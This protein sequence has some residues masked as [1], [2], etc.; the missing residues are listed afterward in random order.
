M[1]QALFPTLDDLRAEHVLVQAW[2]K[3]ATY[4][5]QHSWYADTLELDYQSLRLP[6]FI[7]ELQERLQSPK[8]WV[9]TPLEMVP[10]PKSQA[11]LYDGKVWKPKESVH[12]KIRPLAHVALPDQVLATAM[13]L[14]LADQVEGR[15]GDPL[16]SIESAENRK[17]VLAYG[18]RLFC[19]ST[20]GL[21]HRWGSSKLFRLYYRDYQ[22]FLRRPEIVASQLKDKAAGRE[23]AIV[24]SDLSK[25][26]DRVRPSLLREQVRPLTIGNDPQFFALFQKVFAWGWKDQ[27]RAL[28]YGQ[29]H[30]I[31]GFDSVALPQGLVASGF[32]ANVAIHFFGTALREH[33][34]LPI[35]P[36]GQLILKDACYYVDDLRLVFL[37]KRRAKE[38]DI[39]RS[40]SKWLQ[41]LLDQ[42]APGLIVEQSKTKVTIAGRKKRFLVQ[43][44]KTA[45]RIQHDVS[46]V[47]DMLHGTE[48]IGAIEGFFHTQKQYSSQTGDKPSHPTGLIEG[49][50]DM[51]DDT[52]ARFAAGKFRR[53]FRSLRPLL[54]NDDESL[55]DI[56]ADRLTANG[57]TDA[58]TTHLVLSKQ[59]LDERG[60][61][62]AATLIEEWV[63]DPGNVRL[64]RIGLDIYP[65]VRFLNNILALLKPGWK[66]QSLDEA[67]REVRL[68]CLAEIFRAGATETGIVTE[69]DCLPKDVKLIEYHARL[70][71]EA[72]A[73]LQASLASRSAE[74]C[75]PWYLLQQVFLYLAAQRHFPEQVTSRSRPQAG[76]LRLHQRFARFVAGNS[77]AKLALKER[78]ILLILAHSAFGHEDVLHRATSGRVSARLLRAVSDISPETARRLWV[79]IK[80]SA[81]STWFRTAH[82]LGLEAPS[83]G[84]TS[85]SLAE[86]AARTDNP[87]WLEDNLLKLALG[88][89]N[90][91]KQWS[92]LL[93]PWQVHCEILFPPGSIFGQ[94]DLRSV[95]IKKGKPQAD[96]LFSIPS[97]C[98]TAEEKERFQLGMLLRFALRG[99]ADFYS[100]IPKSYRNSV[101]RYR[102][103]VSHWEKQRYATFQGRTAFGPSWIP[104][105]SWVER[106]LFDLLRW[107][108]VGVV[109]VVSVPKDLASWQIELNDRINQLKTRYGAASKLPF[110]EHKAPPPI[111]HGDKWNRQLRIGIVQSVTP[112][113]DDYAT[114]FNDP[115]LLN[116]PVIRAK[117]RAHLAG[118]MESVSQMLR[119]RKSHMD[120]SK[121]DGSNIDLL[122]FPELAVHPLDVDS[123]ILPFVRSQKC[124]V[125]FGQVYH[126]KDFNPAANLI[127]SCLWVIPEWNH[128][129]GFQVR[130]VEQGKQNL[131]SDER[132][133]FTPAPIEFRPAQ[134]IIEYQWDSNRLERPLKLS[135]SICYDATDLGLASDLKSRSD[136]YIVCALN[137]DVGT[138]DR[139][140]EGLH[141][142]MYQGVIV[143]NNGQ[144]G[145]SSFYMPFGES[146][147]R[148]VFHL[149][150]QPQASI[151]FAEITP[152]KLINRPSQNINTPPVGEWKTH[153]ANWNPF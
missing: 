68:Y 47:F 56:A 99:S 127:N 6:D 59:Q 96:H 132:T 129:N 50:S 128:T 11:W 34:D 136:L 78:S 43:Q 44:S 76:K 23:I 33:F 51:R 61:L 14:C 12:E 85:Q 5:R 16:L 38:A 64:L 143:V 153:P 49:I 133:M 46:G 67:E 126:P 70:Q 73:I 107:P 103:P 106:F 17:R 55:L 117:Q 86:W 93:T 104:I 150:G 4:L 109:S 77:S 112:H 124:I 138:F 30:E 42:N 74:K 121:F 149:H 40:V 137:R 9:A 151:A 75:F 142:H 25:F 20:D 2:K 7:R 144:F 148:Q 65:D 123:L 140:S 18:H 116:D 108:G 82:S 120:H 118:V 13:L 45:Q 36:E 122:I 52:A 58:R 145:G 111:K 39:Q 87:F 15:M 97:W 105:S 81:S 84:L 26:Y 110:L 63:R 88:L 48:L 94:L 71:K 66:N 3:T 146:F 10:A 95:K 22:T 141:Y 147:H 115:Q 135:A 80:P 152:E 92:N 8:L 83:T 19:D 27:A 139:M 100:S 29:R 21:R 134:W 102:S 131:T 119:L 35:D 41:H 24:Q 31:P 69:K 57:L 114:H 54:Q 62:F 1:K 89:L 72:A 37:V 125:L 130:I 101:A 32:F 79:M 91:R 90:R 53:T 113:M 28:A 60:Q 98:E